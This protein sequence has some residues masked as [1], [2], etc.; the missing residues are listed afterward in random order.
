MAM[1]YEIASS[2]YFSSYE[3]TR[4]L[5]R[6]ESPIHGVFGVLIISL[7]FFTFGQNCLGNRQ[8]ASSSPNVDEKAYDQARSISLAFHQAAQK[9]LPASVKI[10]VK[11]NALEKNGPNSK[12]PLSELIPDLEEKALIESGGSGFL[13]DPSGVIVTNAH[14]V[15]EYEIGKT[16]IYEIGNTEITSIYFSQDTY[17]N[18]IIYYTMQVSEEDN[19]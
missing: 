8:D 1:S 16:G 18:S 11:K 6:F 2:Q 15:R 9:T 14:V 3:A 19:L 10:I 5:R 7:S 12:I 4:M 17:E 13:V